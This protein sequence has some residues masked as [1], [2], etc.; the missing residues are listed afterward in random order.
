MK[1]SWYVANVL[2]NI[3]MGSRGPNAVQRTNRKGF[4]CPSEVKKSLAPVCEIDVPRTG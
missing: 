4:K 2:L 3:G 1:V